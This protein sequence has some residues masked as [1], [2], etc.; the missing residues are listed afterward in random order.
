[1]VRTL[2]AAGVGKITFIMDRGFDDLKVFKWLK[3]M[4]H[5]NFVIRVQHLDRLV[6]RSPQHDVQHLVT[7]LDAAPAQGRFM[8]KRPVKNAAGQ[9]SWRP[10]QTEVRATEVWV[11]DLTF[12]L[13]AVRLRFPGKPKGEQDGWVLLTTL[14][15]SSLLESGLVVELYLKWWS[16][17]DVFEW[18]KQALGWEAVRLLD[19]L[20]LQRLVACVWIAVAFAF[21]L[22]EA[23]E[24]PE[25]KL[26]ASLGGDI[27]PAGRPP[28]K[29]ILLRG[30][31]R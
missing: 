22:G 2:R 7:L 17:E 30:L 19:F 14:P 16:I 10:T 25:V 21:R 23:K 8:L 4:L 24:T 13:N 1:M 26:L 15:V 29:K 9:V 31:R 27:F 12:P 11:N 20:A 3:L 6:Q 18:T 5:V 28:G